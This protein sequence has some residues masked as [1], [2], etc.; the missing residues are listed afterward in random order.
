MII[1]KLQRVNQTR[2]FE[3]ASDQ[4]RE[5]IKDGQLKPGDKASHRAGAL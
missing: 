3:Y 5:L 2:V 1:D 4:I